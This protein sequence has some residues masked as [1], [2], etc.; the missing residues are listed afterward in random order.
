LSTINVHNELIAM[1]AYRDRVIDPAQTWERVRPLLSKFG[2]TRV[3]RLTDLDR[4]GIPVWNA[5][6]PNS[7]SLVISQGKG[8]T[9][10][11]ARVSAAMEALERAIAGEPC[12]SPVLCSRAELTKQGACSLSLPEYIAANELDIQDQEYLHWIPGCD[13]VGGE[14]VYVPLD[15]VVLDRTPE[16]P[17]FWQSSDGLASGN[18]SDEAILHALLERVERDAHALWEVTPI[19]A[20]AETCFRAGD[21]GDPVIDDLVERITSAGMTIKLFDITTDIGIPVVT[22]L[23]APSEFHQQRYLRFVDVS[24]GSGCHPDLNRA[25][26]RAITEAAQSRMTFISGARDDIDP[27]AFDRPCPADT[28]R[29]LSLAEQRD[30]KPAGAL[31]LDVAALRDFVLKRLTSSGVPRVV[32]IDLA[33]PA[34]PLSVVKVIIPRLESPDG[35]RARRFG[36]RALSRALEAG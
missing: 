29:C 35:N 30:V 4:L 6:A 16:R 12:L 33:D 2:I 18:S 21:L 1:D 14:T 25:T 31:G 20:R 3:A 32:V 7:R 11:D 5:V 8:I 34:L 28:L 23:L 36:H 26:I 19:G 17:R 15:A 13:L 24:V 27:K 9:D 10:L 22:A